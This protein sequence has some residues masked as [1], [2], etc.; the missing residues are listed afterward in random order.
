MRNPS[1]E[2]TARRQRLFVVSLVAILLGFLVIVQLRSQ[3][4]VARSL[5]NQDNTSIALL[6]NDLN[7]ANGQLLQQGIDLDQRQQ[8]LQQGLVAG[9]TDTRAIEKELAV[10]RMVAGALPVH[11][12][13][14]EI[15]IAGPV[16]DFELQDALNNLRN[17][18]AEAAALNGYR[19]INGTPIQSRGNGLEVAGHL[20]T[21]PFALTVIGDPEQLQ[22]A[23]DLSASSLQTRVQVTITR[24]SDLTITE[25]VA[26]KPLLYSQLGS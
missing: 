6:I 5:A 23:A 13:G 4:R 7:H 10:L 24:R 20:V 22:S 9:G 11:G 17:A 26:P 15:R 19:I 14:L 25:V 12:P 18:G 1:A 21:S 8:A 16:M 3:D 2:R